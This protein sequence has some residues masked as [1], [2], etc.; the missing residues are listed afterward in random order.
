MDNTDAEG[1][2]VKKSP[3]ETTKPSPSSAVSVV[4]TIAPVDI[5]EPPFQTVTHT[6]SSS[7]SAPRTAYTSAVP[8]SYGLPIVVTR[9]SIE[10]LKTPFQP[11]TTT[12]FPSA[13][14]PAILSPIFLPR[15]P[16]LETTD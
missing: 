7:S 12:I 3:L 8:F 14:V 1:K 10:I 6:L 11:V 13:E 15:K 4:V 5:E 9:V 2:G 16:S